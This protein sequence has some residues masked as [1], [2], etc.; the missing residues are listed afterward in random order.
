MNKKIWHFSKGTTVWLYRFFEAFVAFCL[1]IFSLAFW[2]LYTEP[3][4]AKFLLPA[5]SK[6]LLPKDSGYSLKVQKAELS[7]EFKE[8][9]LFHLSMRDLQ[10][11][12]PDETVAV[13]LPVVELSYG[14]WHIMTL[15]YMPDKLIVERPDIHVVIDSEGN[16]RFADKEDAAVPVPAKKKNKRL[17][18]MRKVLN[19]LLSFY[20][21]SI[22]SGMLTVED[23]EQKEKL[24]LPQFDL[25][26]YRRYGGLHHVASVKAVAQLGESLTDI[27]MKASYNRLTKNLSVETGVTPLPVT[28]FGRFMSLLNGI[29]MSVAISMAADFNL[30]KKYSHFWESLDKAKF[31]VKTLDKGTLALPSPIAASYAIRT[32]EINGAVS[33]S[34]KTVRIAKSK[35]EL[36]E[37]SSG[38]IEVTVK[39]LDK[40]FR[41]S[42]I[43]DIQTTLLATVYNVPM[44]DVPKVWPAEQGPDAHVWVEE[45]LSQGRVPQADFR[46]V[47]KGDEMDDVFGDVQTEGVRVDYLPD[48]PA[49][50]NVAAH[51]LLYPNKVEI[52]SDTGSAGNVRLMD[53]KLLFAPLDAEITDLDI[54]LDLSG[55][56]AEM[57]EAIN[58]QP[59]ALL[60]GIDFDWKHITGQADT[61]VLLKFP[62]DENILVDNLK[63]EVQATTKDAG[64]SLKQKPAVLDNGKLQLFVNNEY[65]TL[66][67]DVDFQNQPISVVWRED[68][69]PKDEMG[70]SLTVMGSIEV[71]TLKSLIP[72]AEKYA[73]GPVTVD[74]L[75]KR[76]VNQTLWQGS[77]NAEL[78]KTILELYPFAV[79]K[80]EDLPASLDVTLSNVAIDFS[81]GQSD[82]SLDGQARKQPMAVQGR[83]MWG[84]DWFI[85]LDKVQLDDN[86]FAAYLGIVKDQ[87]KLDVKG[88]KWNLS[89]LMDMPFLK[90]TGGQGKT[91]WSPHMQLKTQLNTLV[92]NPAKPMEKIT[93][94]AL[95]KENLWKY[96]QI[97]SEMEKPLFVVY[98]PEKRLFEGM[99]NDLGEWMSYLNISDR[100]VGGH[101]K[102]SATQDEKGIVKGKIWVDKTEMTEPGALMQ[103]ISILGIVDAIRGSN[104]VFDEIQVPFELKPEGELN[105]NDGYAAGS[106]LGVT[107]RGIVNLDNVDIAGSVIPAYVLNSLPGKIPLIGALFREGDGGG[108]IGVKYSVKGKPTQTEV[109]FH[110]LSSIAPG[111]LGYIF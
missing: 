22:T 33:S 5:L 21:L 56:I 53:A 26:V 103:A 97:E 30:R 107:F 27:K 8:D 90:S 101:L 109:E 73:T 12:R 31:Q 16:W 38:E 54:Q 13:N 78:T 94:N 24:S 3:M 99:A 66:Q 72:D 9:G 70:T 100:F 7:A 65:L 86:D 14:F 50:E 51:V 81:S 92:L 84:Q 87:L 106:N 15:N 19:H 49:L 6:E 57:L 39:G 43:E 35:V 111:A 105:L 48:M 95:R 88:D 77:V 59:L 85:E 42:K 2:K 44:A 46:L 102:L 25:H 108:L 69:E 98:N 32:A 28:K 89:K 64:L 74:A 63:V 20:N 91:I 58:K 83:V 71:G 80:E 4:D 52:I 17:I 55:P 18:S 45:H 76:K 10:L 60:E 61:R 68:F 1:V 67:G 47:F 41:D 104:L 79:T 40:F 62:L 82:F 37:D 29:D 36:N 93:I 96:L 110:P 23:L 75:L 34:F 11:V